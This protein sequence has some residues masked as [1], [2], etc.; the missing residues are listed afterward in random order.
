MENISGNI[1]VT[2]VA[3]K[4]RN[5]VT[6]GQK[7]DGIFDYVN[8]LLIKNRSNNVKIQWDYYMH[9]FRLFF[10]WYMP[11]EIKILKKKS[12]FTIYVKH[13]APL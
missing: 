1:L 8:V 11:F 9:F 3:S 7:W 4:K 13:S 6:G 12:M 10:S 2:W 5:I